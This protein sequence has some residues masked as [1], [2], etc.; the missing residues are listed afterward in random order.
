M[1]SEM[2]VEDRTRGSMLLKRRCVTQKDSVSL[3][4]SLPA[5]RPS[6]SLSMRNCVGLC[7]CA[8]VHACL[9]SCLRLC[10]CEYCTQIPKYGGTHD[11]CVREALSALGDPVPVWIVPEF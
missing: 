7:A 4:L 10:V 2:Q 3:S 1:R 8:R 5:L 11:M 9:R 6:L